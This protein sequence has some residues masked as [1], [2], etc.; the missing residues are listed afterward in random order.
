MVENKFK[1]EII[2]IMTISW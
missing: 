1:Y 2:N